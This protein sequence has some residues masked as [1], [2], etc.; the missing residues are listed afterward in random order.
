LDC[1]AK[2]YRQYCDDAGKRGEEEA[3]H[4]PLANSAAEQSFDIKPDWSLWP[5]RLFT[6]FIR[7]NIFRTEASYNNYIGGSCIHC[8]D[9]GD[10]AIELAVYRL[11][12]W[13]TS[14][15]T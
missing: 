11:E 14:F 5:D 3:L 12:F 4:R 6:L 1:L 10:L 15:E 13:Y 8:D 7:I 2:T 9:A